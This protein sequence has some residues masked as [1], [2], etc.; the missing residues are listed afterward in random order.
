MCVCG[1]TQSR[2][3]AV[4]VGEGGRGLAA[5]GAQPKRRGERCSRHQATAYAPA[6]VSKLQRAPGC[7]PAAHASPSTVRRCCCLDSS[8]A[9]AAHS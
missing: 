8:L 7:G 6:A 3:C 9:W 5:H 2:A 4:T 1:L